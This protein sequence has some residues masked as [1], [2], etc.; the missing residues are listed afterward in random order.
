MARAVF[1]LYFFISLILCVFFTYVKTYQMP[2]SY[3]QIF[4]ISEIFHY[5]AYLLVGVFFFLIGYH[6]VRLQTTTIS[7]VSFDSAIDR[8]HKYRKLFIS[9]QLLIVFYF[10]SK[11]FVGIEYENGEQYVKNYRPLGDKISSLLL[12]IQSALVV[13]LSKHARDR[14]LVISCSLVIS[15]MFAWIDASRAAVLP[16]VGVV[17]IFYKKKKYI[18]FSFYFALLILFY[19][20]AIVGRSY[21]DRIGYGALG[22]IVNT[23]ITGFDEVLVWVVSY[24]TAFSIFQFAYVTRDALGDYTFYDLIYSIVPVPSFFWGNVPDYDNWRADEFRPMGAVSE[25]FRVSQYAMYFYFFIVGCLAKFVDGIK[26]NTL[27]LFALA[28]F[29]MTSVMMFQYNLRTIQWF[30]HLIIILF[31]FDYLYFRRRV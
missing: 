14:V 24:F 23:T 28:V 26:I 4:E 10:V 20:M 11:L 29:L 2:F 9:A 13:F 16:L 12:L 17:Y 21:V 3:E 18:H 30:Y 5:S 1:L 8:L 22:E 31:L 6:C 15:F 19:M 7:S 27:K 25:V